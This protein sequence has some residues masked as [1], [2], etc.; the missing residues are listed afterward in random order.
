MKKFLLFL[1][2]AC[3]AIVLS[4]RAG[5][6][7]GTALCPED[8]CLVVNEASSNSI[9][10]AE[11]YVKMR[12]IPAHHVITVNVPREFYEIK[13]SLAP[14]EFT[15]MIWEP[16]QRTLEERKLSDKILAL[17]YS[18]DFPIRIEA[19]PP[20]SITGI[21]FLRNSVPPGAPWDYGRY[22]SVIFAGPKTEKQSVRDSK[23]FAAIKALFPVSMPL[24]SMMLGYVQERGNTVEEVL[25]CLQRG[26]KSDKSAPRGIVYLAMNEDV[27]SLCRQWQFPE[28]ANRIRMFNKNVGVLND[29]MLP[30]GEKLI[31]FMVGSAVPKPLKAT[32][33]HGAYA[34]HLTSF[35]GA[36]DVHAQVKMSTWITQ[37]A[38]ATSGTVTE[39]FAVAAKFPDAYLFLHQQHGLTMIESIYL[40]TLCPLQLLPLGEPLANPWKKK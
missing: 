17:I 6:N 23:S 32:F 36:F 40:S 18:C 4:L 14:D 34:D 11:A 24:P 25:E 1:T 19:T 2:I 10:V 31:G 13:S 9:R 29:K 27:R 33:Q 3:G 21:T 28:A 30:N 39:P 15:K 38:T 22:E 26:V 8:I 5:T 37:G 7:V 16:V 12:K 20:L 35:A